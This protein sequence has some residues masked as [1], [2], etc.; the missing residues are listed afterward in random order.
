M[1]G[2]KVVGTNAVIDHRCSCSGDNLGV[3]LFDV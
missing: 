3:N 2:G 1:Y